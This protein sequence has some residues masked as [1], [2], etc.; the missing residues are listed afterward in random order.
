MVQR[1]LSNKI[2]NQASGLQSRFNSFVNRAFKNLTIYS[3]I[4]C[5]S[6]AVLLILAEWGIMFHVEFPPY[7]Y[8]SILYEV[9]EYMFLR[10]KL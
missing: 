2:T 3:C 7:M 1:A 5:L 6:W 10:I 8:V 9:V 4:S